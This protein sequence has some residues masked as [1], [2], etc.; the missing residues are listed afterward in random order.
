VTVTT[1]G[2]TSAAAQ[3]AYDSGGGV[4]TIAGLSPNH[5]PAAG[6]NQVT[7]TGSG[8][9]G[10]TAVTFGSNAGTGINVVDDGQL[11]V[12]APAASSSGSVD[13]T[14]TTPGG[15]SAAAQYAYDS[16]GGVPTRPRQ[17]R[18]GST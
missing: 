1:P 15:T 16:G 17:R 8:L 11:T 6:A 4:P 2:G 10:A 14:V 9:T 12:T 13:V 5:G 18:R 7:V 3:Y